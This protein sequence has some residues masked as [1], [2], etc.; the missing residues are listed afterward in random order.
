[1]KRTRRRLWTW[2]I[3][4]GAS[5]IVTAATLS[6]LF[7]IA[8]TMV[9]A[10]REQLQDY[11]GHALG[12]P[13]HLGSVALLWHG[14]APVLDLQQI[15]LLTAPGGVPAIR[16]ER[17][18]FAFSL[19]RLLA[20]DRRP[21]Q[22]VLSGLQLRLHADREGR[23]TLTGGTAHALDLVA[24]LR[25][26]AHF[27]RLQIERGSVVLDD[28]RL[29][30]KPLQLALTSLQ[31]LGD[32]GH[33]R[34]EASL[35]PPPELGQ[36]LS[37]RGEIDGDNDRPEDWQGHAELQLDGV[38]GWPWLDRRLRSGDAIRYDGARLQ[39]QARWRGVHMQAIDMQFSAAGVRAEHAGLPVQTLQG[40]RLDA[41]I[42]PN[43]SGWHIDL[44]PRLGSAAAAPRL[45]LDVA[46]QDGATRLSLAADTLQL[47]DFTP[48]L[49]LA[50]LPA[51][52]AE[53]LPDL[54]GS[55]RNLQVA[56]E[57][58]DPED[59][60][61][62][63]AARP[64]ARYQ[65]SADLEA[66]SLAARGELPAARGLSGHL[67]A[68]NGGGSLRLDEIPLQLSL[69]QV[70][71]RVV[72]FE[73]LSGT[74]QWRH[75][76]DGWSL[77]VPDWQF[78]LAGSSG[79]GRFAVQFPA[80][81]ASPQLDLH[82]EFAAAEAAALKPWMPRRW[83]PH[84]RAWVE[85]AI[86]HAVASNG[87]I[88]LHGALADFPYVEH[89]SGRWSVDVDL[90]DVRLAYA[91]DWPAAEGGRAHLSLSGRSL[92]V[93]AEQGQIGD[94]RVDAVSAQVDDTKATDL[95]L[96][97]QLHGDGGAFY[98][99]LRDS[100]LH[101]RLAGLLDR[102]DLAGASRLD[103]RL[104]V[105]LHAGHPP[106]HS[107][108]RVDLFDAR[109]QVHGVPTAISALNGSLRFNGPRVRAE[110]L[111]ARFDDLQLEGRIDGD[112]PPPPLA[113]PV[114]V[115][116]AAAADGSEALALAPLPAD[117]ATVGTLRLQFD[118]PVDAE[119]GVFARYVPSVVRQRLGGRSHW[120]AELALAGP[121]SG[122]L[123]LSSDLFGV[124]S[125]LPA[126][127]HKRS[128]ER[129]PLQ[130]Q[131]RSD[132]V[133]LRVLLGTSDEALR[134]ALRFARD[135]EHLNLQGLEAQFGAG[136]A[137]LG[138]ADGIVVVG[139]PESLDLGWFTLF[140]RSLTAASD[141]AAADAAGDGAHLALPLNRLDLQAQS[142]RYGHYRL[143]ATRLQNVAD[144][145]AW[146][147]QLS[148]EGAT[149]RI[150]G[151]SEAGGRLHA[152][153]QRLQL[154]LLPTPVSDAAASDAAAAEPETNPST[155]TAPTAATAA[156]TAAPA[157]VEPVA[158]MKSSPIDP[159]AWPVLDL[160]C[161]QVRVGDA[162]LGSLR[163]QTSRLPQGQRIER[164][165]LHGGALQVD[166]QGQ[167][168]RGASGSSAVAQFS[169]DSHDL[170]TVLRAFHYA[171][172]LSGE[173]ARFTARLRW[174]EQ[175]AGLDA[176]LAEGS[177]HLEVD[178]G[179]LTAVDPGAGRVLGLLNF[180]ALPRRLTL[181]FSDVTSKGLGFDRL[182]GSFKLAGGNATTDDL[183][184]Q[185]PSLRMQVRGRIGLV[186]RDY[187]ERVIVYPGVSS[188]VALGVGLLGGPAGAAIALLA[189]QL[190]SK[191][192]D[193]LTQFSYHVVG[194]WDN[195]QLHRGESASAPAGAVPDAA[196]GQPGSQ[197][198]K[199]G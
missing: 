36:A 30:G 27:Q 138:N 170:A 18:Q 127:L 174:R 1:M 152:D 136:A 93:D 68:G 51:A 45:A 40:V 183:E 163:L 159:S 176:R 24:A 90:S 39:A 121:D 72:P 156:A 133:P 46:P 13:A 102:T 6:G 197:E 26:V 10:Y 148:G 9:P 162:S 62:P 54:H 5:L 55:V 140:G 8:V 57:P 114:V 117:A 11:V 135:G 173:Q 105:P 142:L 150:D 189:Q 166:A 44:L 132:G 17:L 104:R 70:F 193:R 120:Q 130:V 85:R 67:E 188:G 84:A 75:D 48:W 129:L 192:L 97:V 145:A 15:E 191:P 59:F 69:P 146:A 94:T 109:M 81:G 20:G 172:S 108:G 177:V 181:N 131:L 88:E 77:G 165:S 198:Q 110:G 139:A 41:H 35:R 63:G 179:T 66:L 199:H 31:L 186:A 124:S 99:V 149:G 113:E 19:R 143:P 91:R 175:P 195:P 185:A 194:G 153:L 80:D 28:E 171:P 184:V 122:R 64:V 37:L 50:P 157:A 190:F 134:L 86:E 56:V 182:Q 106:L 32:S 87:R 96:H 73:A 3:T 4:L 47:D 126:P 151:S 119:T 76:A 180:Y 74:L 158:A 95:D 82:G 141:G 103:L 147:L 21:S 115:P 22:L 178:R 25:A 169:A 154:E 29:P 160:Q 155:A 2:L 12:R 168:L 79:Q 164:F 116:A 60:D 128:D 23:L 98:S 71:E 49:Q 137:P 123:R 38:A 16:A 101:G 196:P 58:P 161:A 107:E 144:G 100:P 61:V 111:R 83:G 34:F 33:R 43:L 92:R 52:V 42:Q 65:L 89:P 125:D 118:T 14:F 167:W 53:R 112:E 187:D 7:R 78:R